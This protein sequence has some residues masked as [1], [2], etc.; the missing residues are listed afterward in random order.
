MT[1][2]KRSPSLQALQA[3]VQ[4]WNLAYDVGTPVIVT[5]DR[6]DKVET[7]TTSKAQVLSGHSAVIW[8][9]GISGAYLLSRVMAQ[10]S[11]MPFGRTVTKVEEEDGLPILTMSCQHTTQIF[12]VT[13]DAANF[14]AAVGSKHYCAQCVNEFVEVSRGAKA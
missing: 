4:Q 14:K 6:G 7:V 11:V 8:L 9:E 10:P 5:K 12:G 1:K 3:Q 2:Q 13:S